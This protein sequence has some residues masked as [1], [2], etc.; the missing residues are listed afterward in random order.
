MPILGEIRE[1]YKRRQQFLKPPN[2]DHGRP[3]YHHLY[4]CLLTLALNECT[5]FTWEELAAHLQYE[6]SPVHVTDDLTEYL[7]R[8]L[9]G[10][11][12]P[13]FRDLFRCEP[14]VICFNRKDGSQ[15][16][17][18]F[19]RALAICEEDLPPDAFYFN[20]VVNRLD[21]SPE[22]YIRREK[23]DDGPPKINLFEYYDAKLNTTSIFMNDLGLGVAPQWGYTQMTIFASPI[24]FE[25]YGF[26][27]FA[28]A[29]KAARGQSSSTEDPSPEATSLTRIHKSFLRSK[30][31]DQA[32][33]LHLRE[34][35]TKD[36]VDAAHVHKATLLTYHDLDR[37]LRVPSQ[38]YIF[39]TGSETDR[40]EKSPLRR[41]EFA[42]TLREWNQLLNVFG[43]AS[44][45]VLNII[46]RRRPPL[47]EEAKGDRRKSQRTKNKVAQQTLKEFADI[48]QGGQ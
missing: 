24:K 27:K 40:E 32:R 6:V 28:A 30:Y 45:E 11:S 25:V 15:Q 47:T 3:R 17:T 14:N 33:L 48:I 18:D 9:S 13:S 31:S 43:L 36:V 5:E 21:D 22:S 16:G 41:T 10:L 4:Y 29:G 20:E 23:C 44:K 7:Q 26:S 1:L 12:P 39:P 35:F 37:F 42:P 8:G 38:D 34:A 2:E 19:V 46:R